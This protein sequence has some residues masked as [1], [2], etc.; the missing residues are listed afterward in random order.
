MDSSITQSGVKPY[1]LYDELV[2]R[3][4]SRTEKAIDIKRVC[5]TISNISTTHKPDEIANH[6]QEI[7]ALILHNELLSNNGILLSY[8]PYDGRLMV[9]GK[10]ILYSITN[11][12]PLLQQIIAQYIENSN[13]MSTIAAS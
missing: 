12:P 13:E 4:H 1:P 10:G 7:A 8:V 11:F 6:Y 2:R 3:V 5:T 9:G